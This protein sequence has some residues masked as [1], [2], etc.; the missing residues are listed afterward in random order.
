MTLAAVAILILG[1][2]SPVAWAQS[3]DWAVARID[4]ASLPK[5]AADAAAANLNADVNELSATADKGRSD[6]VPEEILVGF[7]GGVL[8][9]HVEAVRGGLGAVEIKTIPRIGVRHWMLPPG[10]NVAQAMQRLAADPRVRF[11]EPNWIYSASV[12][13]ADN[14][15]NPNDPS[16]IPRAGWTF[17]YQEHLRHDGAISR[18]IHA[19]EAWD[20]SPMGTGVVVAVL[21][22]GVDLDHPDLDESLFR[23]G[24]GNIIGRNFVKTT[25]PPKDDAGHGTHVAGII[26]AEINNFGDRLLATRALDPSLGDGVAGVA[27]FARIMPIKVLD[28][29]GRGTADWISQGII[30]AADN[31][32]QI[33]NMSLGGPFSQT[34]QD[35]VTYAYG[36]NVLIVV[37]AGNSSAESSDY[38][39]A[40]AYTLSVVAVDSNDVLA[41][42]S[43]YGWSVDVSAPGVNILSTVIDGDSPK[44][45]SGAYARMS[46]T[47]MASPMAAGVAALIKSKYPAMSAADV[48]GQLLATAADVAADNPGYETKLG[49]GRVDA[50]GA[51]GAVSAPVVI[52]MQVEGGPGGAFG[53]LQ[54]SLKF[55]HAMNAASVL[56][57]ANYSLLHA[58]PDG[59]LGT[60]DDVPVALS[61]VSTAYE[62]FPG[63]GVQILASGAPDGNYRF[64]ANSTIQSAKGEPLAA[65]TSDFVWVRSPWMNG[66][67]LALAGLHATR[68][69]LAYG[70]TGQP[71]IAFSD[72]LNKDGTMDTTRFAQWNGTSWVFETIGPGGNGISL[73]YN[74]EGNPSASSFPADGVLKFAC[75]SGASWT[76][77]NVDTN[78]SGGQ[79]SLAYDPAGNPSISYY[80]FTSKGNTWL[81]TLKFARRNGSTWVTQVVEAPW[82]MKSGSMPPYNSLAYGPDGNP[83]IAYSRDNDGDGIHDT[84]KMAHW[85]GSSWDIQII[86][87]G[88]R[89][90][91]YYASLA[92]DPVDHNPS[93][94]H[95]LGN[96]FVHWNGGAWQAS[97]FHPDADAGE[98]CR[99]VY[100]ASGT[101]FIGHRY[102]GSEMDE[103][104]VT[105]W[106]GTAWETET[107]DRVL[108]VSG[109]PSIAIDPGTNT[110]S[111]AYCEQTGAS[112]YNLKFARRAP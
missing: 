51:V 78:V 31:G 77:T 95:G 96:R 102:Y 55:S 27:P 15:A 16:F 24:A 46:G 1:L 110:P 62:S 107:A 73:A 61:M 49:A 38:P 5:L 56:N 54:I 35:A 71:A 84:L 22:T 109:R 41:S 25:N 100:D 70:P 37:A 60:G 101:P 90:Y 69:S 98:D 103:M 13:Y 91:G 64:T 11:A 92:Y 33:I 6:S 39:A 63:Q 50:F 43:N 94:V 93:V 30:W 48:G 20:A 85:N 72:D 45:V 67:V 34:M 58:G 36:K 42:F 18:E 21:D 2:A 86:E 111:V 28:S 68:P 12:P 10:L 87:A 17:G 3:P 80:G 66:I 83:T 8:P 47:S 4:A 75:R 29:S 76:T 74:G 106:N 32:A 108:I 59:I 53:S 26:A 105:H 7:H 82:G 81:W 44:W 23:D 14:S 79:T 104:L 9:A 57:A 97:C 19:E 99:L 52:V 89:G 40:C 65:F 88:V 112:N